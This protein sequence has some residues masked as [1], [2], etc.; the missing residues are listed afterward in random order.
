MYR[1]LLQ[2][3]QNICE[4]MRRTRKILQYFELYTFCF[5]G[6]V[7]LTCSYFVTLVFTYVGACVCLIPEYGSEKN[8]EVCI[9]CLIGRTVMDS[10]RLL[11]VGS[12]EY[13]YPIRSG[14][15]AIYRKILDTRQRSVYYVIGPDPLSQH[16]SL[17]H[18]RFQGNC[19]NELSS[20][21]P[22]LH[23]TIHEDIKFRINCQDCFYY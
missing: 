20:L 8:Q 1:Q 9:I 11:T 22:R 4:R 16:Q 13:Q 19:A 3:H 15:P 10:V 5:I 14:A 2:L 6:R 7:V 18:R 23:E 21:V 17:P 12:I